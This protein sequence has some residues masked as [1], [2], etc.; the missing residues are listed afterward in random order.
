[1]LAKAVLAKA[2]LAKAVLAKAVLEQAVL[3]KALFRRCTRAVAAPMATAVTMRWCW[4]RRWRQWPSRWPGRRL[5]DF[6]AK[7]PPHLSIFGRLIAP[8]GEMVTTGGWSNGGLAFF[9]YL[10]T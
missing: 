6:R 2:V 5:A 4:W 8:P 3:A 10:S 9:L 1:M 7:F